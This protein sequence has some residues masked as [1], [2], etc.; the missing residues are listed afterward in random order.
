METKKRQIFP[1]VAHIGYI[2]DCIKDN[3]IVFTELFGIDKFDIYEYKPIHAWAYGKEIYDCHFSIAM[4]TAQNGMSIE[5]IQPISGCSTPQMEFMK[6]CGAGIHHFS[7]SVKDFD[8]WKTYI[9]SIQN[10]NIIFEAEVN[11]KKRGY[12]RCI[13]V[14]IGK[15]CPVIE[16]AEVPRKSRKEVNGII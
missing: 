10:A 13:Y 4:G 8:F 2:V 5:L 14:Q 1:P 15:A 11:D 7:M 9:M 12:R 6:H 16:L 3:I